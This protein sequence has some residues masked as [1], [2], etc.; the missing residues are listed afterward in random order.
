MKKIWTFLIFLACSSICYADNANKDT[1]MFQKLFSDWTNAFNRK[2]I[3]PSCA[4][5][6]KSLQ[7]DYRG[8]PSKTYTSIC[9]GFKQVFSDPARHYHYRFKIRHVYRS[10]NLAAV[11][12]TWYLDVTENQKIILSTHDEGLDILEKTSAGW[13]IVNY[14]A[15]DVTEQKYP[16]NMPAPPQK[17]TPELKPKK[18]KKPEPTAGVVQI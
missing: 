3:N 16:I 8:A 14:L 10:G 15:Y 5:F 4:L 17:P 1:A 9:N 11:R 12:I 18:T 13:K 2:Q 7:A 6:A